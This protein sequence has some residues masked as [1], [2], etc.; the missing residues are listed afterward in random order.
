MMRKLSRWMT[1]QI[2]HSPTLINVTELH[3]SIAFPFP[4]EQ[5]NDNISVDDNTLVSGVP[6][7]CD[8]VVAMSCHA[9]IDDRNDETEMDTCE[10]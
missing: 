10:L 8:F 2:L 4:K 1:H 3:L 6:T 7:G 5:T 9:V